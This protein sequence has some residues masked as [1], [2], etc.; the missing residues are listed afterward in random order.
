M[1]TKQFIRQL[2]ERTG[3]SAQEVETLID[4]LSEI[5][6]DRCSKMDSIAIPGFG[7]FEPRKRVERVNVHP[8]TGKKILIPPKISLSFKMSAVLK[9]KLR[10]K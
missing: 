10:S 1:D 9:N 6:K 7:T 8:T 5:I 2:S 3:R 4:G